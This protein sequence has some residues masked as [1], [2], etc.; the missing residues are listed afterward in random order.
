MLLPLKK[1]K[2]KNKMV[3]FILA[4]IIGCAFEYLISMFG[5]YVL[6]VKWW[7]YTDY[8]LNI[9]GRT[10]LYFGILW[11]ILGLFLIQTLNP[12]VDLIIDNAKERVSSQLQ[13]SLVVMVSISLLLDMLLS[14]I[15]VDFYETR[16]IVENNINVEASLREHY[17]EKYERVY[18]NPK[19]KAMIH[20]AWGNE[21][22]IKTFPN[23]KIK[24]ASG[25]VIYLTSYYPDIQNYYFKIFDSGAINVIDANNESDE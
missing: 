4:G 15:A 18:S 22:M 25:D 2:T 16:V 7:D 23:L 17:E 10:C 3:I 13:V 11:G 5:D 9:N 19:L 21:V 8:F 24:D 20:A 6:H 1:L 14:I 12:V